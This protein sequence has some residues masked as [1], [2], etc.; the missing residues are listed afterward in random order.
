MMYIQNTSLPIY[1][2]YSLMPAYC[3]SQNFFNNCD[4]VPFRNCDSCSVPLAKAFLSI[5][6]LFSLASLLGNA[7]VII[8]VYTRKPRTRQEYVRASLA[9]ANSIIGIIAVSVYVPNIFWSLDSTLTDVVVMVKK[10]YNTVRSN[11]AGMA[12][13][14]AYFCSLNHLFYM[15]IQRFT[16]VRWPFWYRQQRLK[17]VFIHLSIVWG[18]SIFGALSPVLWPDLGGYMYVNNALT[19][20]PTVSHSRRG[21]SSQKL[22]PLLTS[23]FFIFVPYLVMTFLTITTGCLVHRRFKQSKK[24]RGKRNSTRENLAK[25][26]ALIT[27]LIRLQLGFTVATAPLGL[28]ILLLAVGILKYERPG[29]PF[30]ISFLFSMWSSM[31]NVA[32][33]S[34]SDSSFRNTVRRLLFFRHAH[35]SNER[36]QE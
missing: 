20:L 31:A 35:S 4:I 30:L 27:T 18:C 34:A 1:D 26:R 25:E 7:L 24:L 23:F 21:R 29:S 9:V 5:L 17:T 14:C 6:I 33:Y 3:F 36:Q 12:F 16:S 19:Y 2:I 28:C 10:T 11:A 32:I 8:A 22:L 13:A 15:S